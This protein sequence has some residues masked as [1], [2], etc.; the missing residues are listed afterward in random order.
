MPVLVC[1]TL[2]RPVWAGVSIDYSGVQLAS[3]PVLYE[4]MLGRGPATMPRSYIHVGHLC[5]S[6]QVPAE[7]YAKEPESAV[8]NPGNERV[9]WWHLVCCWDMDVDSYHFAPSR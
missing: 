9:L 5:V 2:P 6:Y 7:L 3:G 8:L 4:G 1:C